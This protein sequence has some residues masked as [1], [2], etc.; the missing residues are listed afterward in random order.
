MSMYK[1]TLTEYPTS[2]EDI[3]YWALENSN[4][5]SPLI[6]VQSLYRIDILEWFSFI[7]SNYPDLLDL[8]FVYVNNS[9]HPTIKIHVANV[10]MIDTTVHQNKVKMYTQE[11][12]VKNISI[13]NLLRAI[14]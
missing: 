7:Q 12:N 3:T 9:I 8:S 1:K 14:R 5:M 2:R 13:V 6:N 10:K 4:N 11:R